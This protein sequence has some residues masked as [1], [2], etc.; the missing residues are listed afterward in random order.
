MPFAEATDNSILN[1]FFDKVAWADT[2][3]NRY[4]GLSS[5]TPTKTGG[6]VTEPSAGAYARVQLVAASMDAAATSA[7]TNNA[8]QTFPQATAD[9]LAAANLTHWV[10]YTAL[11]VGTFLASKALTVAKP[12]L[13]GDTAKFAAG[14]MDFTIAGAA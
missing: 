14:D 2:A 4:S 8:D 7:T 13:N 11:T 6:N 10:L 5:T 12:V 9:W 3:E 1:H